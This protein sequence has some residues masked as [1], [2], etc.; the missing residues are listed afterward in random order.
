M[1]AIREGITF[2]G[3]H[4]RYYGLM[5]MTRSAPTPE[6]KTIVDDVPFMQGVYDFSMITGERIFNNRTVSYEFWAVNRN[7]E[8][9]KVF[10]LALKNWLMLPGILPVYDTHDFNYHWLGKCASVEVE[11]DTEY[12]RLIV[13]VDFD[14]YPFKVAELPSGND[15]WDVFNFELDA[16]QKTKYTITGTQTVN[17]YNVGIASIVPTVKT[18]A[19]MTIERDGTTYQFPA[20]ESRNELFRLKLGQNTLKITGTGTIEFIFYKELI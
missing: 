6:E 5:M 2:N 11:D 18:S 3:K 1:E 13:N 14:C 16:A 17:L 20:G 15:F 12:N 8:A 10:E 7:Y 4:S 19:A 9:R